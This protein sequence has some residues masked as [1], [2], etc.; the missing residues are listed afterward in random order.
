M[1][2]VHHD[3]IKQTVRK[4]YGKIAKAGMSGC[5]CSCSPSGGYS[6]G[7][8]D[9]VPRG[10]DLGLGSGNPLAIA[11]IQPGETVIDLGSGGG[12]DCFLAA[13]AVGDDGLVIGIDMTPEMVSR[14][15]ANAEEGGYSNVDFRLGEIENL[16]VA[17][18]SADVIMSNCAINLS[19]DKASVYGEAFRVLKPG[20]RVAISDIV[21]TVDLPDEARGDLEQYA[22]CV[23]GAAS[24]NEL[25]E[26]LTKAG[27][28]GIGIQPRSG[29]RDIPDAWKPGN[30][31][32]DYTV[33]ANV[34][35]VRPV[36]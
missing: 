18:S 16:P 14:A 7:E 21:T 24:I 33:S 1:S 17:D 9:N 25:K 23:S 36:G 22:A 30:D 32:N 31:I 28:E 10:A 13:N 11:D 5:G 12:I 19:P 3:N 35:A 20:G 6:Q 27:F 26:I 15:R 4:T 29:A 2:T 34:K 8:R